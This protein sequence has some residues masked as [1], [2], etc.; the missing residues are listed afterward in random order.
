MKKFSYIFVV[1]D[2]EKFI[3]RSKSI[4]DNGGQKILGLCEKPYQAIVT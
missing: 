2:D 1:K 3:Y 4:S